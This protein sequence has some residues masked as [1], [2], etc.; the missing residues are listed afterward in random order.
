M[1]EEFNAGDKNVIARVEEGVL[2]RDKSQEALEIGQWSAGEVTTI[3]V[4]RE[5]NQFYFYKVENVTPPQPKKLSEAR[6]YI[7]ADYQDYL[8]Q[9]WVESLRAK[10]PV[11]VDQN[12]FEKMIRQK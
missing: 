2:E 5:S 1:L 6:G 3:K 8:E 10:Y 4:D 7:V 11:K 9:E 12:V